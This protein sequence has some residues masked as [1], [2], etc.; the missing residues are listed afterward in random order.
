MKA[1]FKALM[2]PGKTN[3]LRKGLGPFIM[4]FAD[5]VVIHDDVTKADQERC[6][7]VRGCR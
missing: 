7:R 2:S 6:H 3:R 5:E 1:A 4:D